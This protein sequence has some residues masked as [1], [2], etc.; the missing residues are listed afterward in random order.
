MDRIP[1][2][3]LLE[4]FRAHFDERYN[5]VSICRK[6]TPWLIAAVCRR[7]RSLV[8]GTPTFWKNI[9]IPPSCDMQSTGPA[10]EAALSQSG[11]LP[12]SV[13]LTQKQCPLSTH[14]RSVLNASIDRWKKLLIWCNEEEDLYFLEDLGFPQCMP[15][16]RQLRLCITSEDDTF[17]L[18]TYLRP[19]SE[20]PVLE[21]FWIDAPPPSTDPDPLDLVCTFEVADFPWEQLVRLKLN[22]P[23]CFKDSL[24]VLQASV[25]LKWLIIGEWVEDDT[26]EDARA[27]PP[28]SLPLLETLEACNIAS[29]PTI[30]RIHC[31]NLVELAIPIFQEWEGRG[32]LESLLEISP[33]PALRTLRITNLNPL[34]E[35]NIGSSLDAITS[36]PSLEVVK[37]R[38]RGCSLPIVLNKLVYLAPSLRLKTICLCRPLKNPLES[39]FCQSNEVA[40]AVQALVAAFQGKEKGT[41]QCVRLDFSSTEY[42]FTGSTRVPESSYIPENL[43]DTPLLQR[44]SELKNINVAITL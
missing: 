32:M 44:L 37:L 42:F 11:K 13:R 28:V 19:F 40:D 29:Y 25:R 39:E 43:W 2:D 41:L 1:N 16:L 21:E 36:L 26:T 30:S 17:D 3:V 14:A 38:F 31:P 22:V 6:N 7:W 20:C 15:Q 23:M 34:T 10:L 33:L 12:I 9:R 24:N 27:F 4:I 8:L 18:A 35:D 5:W